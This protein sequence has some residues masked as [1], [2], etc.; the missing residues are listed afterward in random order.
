MGFIINPIAHVIGG[1]G[2]AVG[3]VFAKP[4][5][6][7]LSASASP[8]VRQKIAPTQKI[9][10]RSDRSTDIAKTLL[11]RAGGGGAG[12]VAI[13]PLGVTGSSGLIGADELGARGYKSLLGR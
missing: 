1:I 10:P 12:G 8:A 9:V 4:K 7:K 13:S 2:R 5:G 3:G 6:P 11:S